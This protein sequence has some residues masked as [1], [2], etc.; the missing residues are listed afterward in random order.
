MNK[1]NKNFKN[2]VISEA[3][4]RSGQVDI[5]PQAQK[6]LDMAPPV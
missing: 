6:T 2:F 5:L 4:W 3:R 1:I